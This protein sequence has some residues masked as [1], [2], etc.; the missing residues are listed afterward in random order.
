MTDE[1]SSTEET[2]ESSPVDQTNELSLHM[3]ASLEQLPQEEFIK[4]QNTLFQSLIRAISVSS[5]EISMQ[6]D[7]IRAEMEKMT[8]VMSLIAVS[9]SV[10]TATQELLGYYGKKESPVADNID[11]SINLSETQLKSIPSE[12]HQQFLTLTREILSMAQ[13][14]KSLLKE[15]VTKAK[16]L[17]QP[18]EILAI[19]RL[20]SKIK[21]VKKPHIWLNY[22]QSNIVG[23]CWTG[24]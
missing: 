15:M 21:K 18:S 12:K 6:L 22:K 7:F 5:M 24:K 23:F 19:A 17:E 13:Q 1:L 20:V 14:I 10:K 9:K 8:N 3:E 4:H 2:K 11:K 16:Q